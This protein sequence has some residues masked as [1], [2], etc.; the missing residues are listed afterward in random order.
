MLINGYYGDGD[1]MLSCI[2]VKLMKGGTDTGASPGFWRYPCLPSLRT[3]LW[4]SHVGHTVQLQSIW[5]WLDQLGGPPVVGSQ[6]TG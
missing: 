2:V 6:L 4:S 5:L 1:V 3:Y